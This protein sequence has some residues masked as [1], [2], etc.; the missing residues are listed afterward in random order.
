MK[1]ISLI[2]VDKKYVSLSR[3]G[4]WLSI[5]IIIAI[6]GLFCFNKITDMQFSNLISKWEN[7]FL[8]F[9]SYQGVSKVSKIKYKKENKDE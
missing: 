1:F 8:I 3:F 6:S 7:I 4:T 5:I 2:S 9:I